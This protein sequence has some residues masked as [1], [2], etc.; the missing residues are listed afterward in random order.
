MRK[1]SGEGGFTM[2][3][4]SVT[5][6]IIG[7]LATIA[8]PSFVTVMPRFRL[9]NA[10][11][12]LANELAMARMAA[13]ARSVDGEAVVNKDTETYTLARTVG[14]GPYVRTTLGSSVGIESL[15][16]G[17]EDDAGTVA[18]SPFTLQLNANGTTN[19][20]LQQKALRITLATAD[21]AHKRRVLVWATGRIH[22]QKWAGGTSWVA[23]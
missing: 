12:T 17:D 6:A 4:M 14:G 16:F 11:Q 19:I 13:I 8:I 22:S 7:I 18:A 9:G 20:A 3:E 23:D 10:T 2:V 15:S 21:G 1:R 5:V